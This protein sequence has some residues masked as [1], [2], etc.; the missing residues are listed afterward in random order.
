M[1]FTFGKRAAAT[2][3]AVLAA[4]MMFS[5]CGGQATQSRRTQRQRWRNR[6]RR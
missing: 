6:H 1:R 5:A 4:T 3:A 2:A